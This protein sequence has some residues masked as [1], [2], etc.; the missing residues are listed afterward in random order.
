M[1]TITKSE[2]DLGYNKIKVR[3]G[4]NATILSQLL[5]PLHP[6][7]SKILFGRQYLFLHYYQTIINNGRL[8]P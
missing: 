2:L 5:P 3:G 4:T 7:T 6:N 1:L 8:L